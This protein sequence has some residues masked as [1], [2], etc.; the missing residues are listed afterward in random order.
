MSGLTLTRVLTAQHIR[1]QQ[2]GTFALVVVIACALLSSHVLLSLPLGAGY[3]VGLLR[4]FKSLRPLAIAQRKTVLF[5]SKN[6]PRIAD[7]VV[8][9]AHQ[10]RALTH[11]EYRLLRDAQMDKWINDVVD[12]TPIHRRYT[13][14]ESYHV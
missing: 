8:Q 14:P 11:G 4:H 6:T 13:S 2:R 12:A 10:Q 1:Q 7:Y 3:T 5:W 9:F